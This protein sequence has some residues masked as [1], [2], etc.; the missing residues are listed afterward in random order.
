MLPFPIQVH[1]KY[2]LFSYFLCII[3]GHLILFGVFSFLSPIKYNSSSY[4]GEK[5]SS[6]QDSTPIKL[7]KYPIIP[8]EDDIIE[9]IAPIL[10]TNNHEIEQDNPK[11]DSTDT[12]SENDGSMSSDFYN[13]YMSQIANILNKHKYYP[14]AEKRRGREGLVAVNFT[15]YP[16]GSVAHVEIS[17][18]C[19]YS[20]LNQ[21]AIDT[22]YRAAPYPSFNTRTGKMNLSVSIE[23]LL[24]SQ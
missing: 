12:Q 7:R 21:A 8:L 4:K 16:D 18:P 23:F 1:K 15:V 10:Q 24:R 17:S 3:F 22:V 13:E 11:T 14:E 6:I 2:S 20:A 9:I 5:S 19:P